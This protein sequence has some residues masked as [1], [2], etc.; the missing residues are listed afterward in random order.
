[1]QDK[2]QEEKR[3]DFYTPIQ[4]ATYE[5]KI[6]HVEGRL[7]LHPQKWTINKYEHLQACSVQVGKEIVGSIKFPF[8]SQLHNLNST[9]SNDSDDGGTVEESSEEELAAQQL[10]VNDE[11]KNVDGTG[12]DHIN[13]FS[14]SVI[15]SLCVDETQQHIS[16]NDILFAQAEHALKEQILAVE[17]RKKT[18]GES[19][20]PVASALQISLA[21]AYLTT[22]QL[23]RKHYRAQEPIKEKLTHSLTTLTEFLKNPTERKADSFIESIKAIRK[24][25]EQDSAAGRGLGIFLI[26]GGFVLMF[27]SFVGLEWL[28]HTLDV[29]VFNEELTPLLTVLLAGFVTGGLAQIMG[30]FVCFAND[31]PSV[32]S[33]L[34]EPKVKYSS[35]FPPAKE[36]LEVEDQLTQ[37]KATTMNNT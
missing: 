33:E 23:L 5:I 26:V 7:A 31:S 12:N 21:E 20:F 4:E 34:E 25:V 27:T 17:N 28:R 22:C 16:M 8:S 6:R 2:A 3:K 11:V 10:V 32:A 24:D 18:S 30:L 37:G 13:L 36:A 35:F 15:E 14:N 9:D 19:T 29:L 1:M